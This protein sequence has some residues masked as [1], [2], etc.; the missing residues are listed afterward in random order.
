MNSHTDYI[1]FN[2][3]N[4][5]EYINITP[6]VEDIVE[7]SGINEGLCLVSSMHITSSVFVNDDERGFLHDLDEMLEELAPEDKDYMHNH[8]SDPNGDAHQKRTLVGHQVVLPVS[9]GKLEL[10]TWEQVFYG[11]FDGQRKKRVL[12]KIIGE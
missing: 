6:E 2:T 7:E 11:E 8:T 12:V 1:W 4:K 10:G 5:R 9:N 3:K